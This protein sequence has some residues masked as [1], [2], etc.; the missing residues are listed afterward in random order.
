M[1]IIHLS[2]LHIGKTVHGFSMTD[3]QRHIFDEIL[4]IIDSE[5]PDAVI[6]AGDIY[7]RT[8]P[9]A[10]AVRLFDGFLYEVTRR[11]TSV[12]I[13][14]GNHDSADRVAFGGRLMSKS[15][16]YISPSYRGAE[17]PVVLHD[18]KGEVR[19]YMLPFIKP[20]HVRAAFDEDDIDTY[21][22]A[23]KR[24]VEK[25][26]IDQSVRNVLIAHQTVTG[27]ERSESE[28]IAVGGVDSVDAHIFDSF[29]YVALGHLHRPQSVLKETVRYSGSPL[30][31]SFSEADHDKSVTV[32][33]LMEKG[34]TSVSTVPLRPLRDMLI[35]RG[36]YMELTDRSFYRDIDRNAYIKAVLTDEDDVPDAMSRLRTVYP[37]I[38][39][40][41]YDNLR[42]RSR[43]FVSAAE[44]TE[45]KSE[46]DLFDDLF[47][48]QNGQRMSPEQREA[49]EEILSE[50]KER[51]R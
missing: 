30:K 3:D 17:D 39:A 2:D 21:E 9:S 15:R 14:S 1:K 29:D 45:K 26:D 6:M 37:N 19:F 48:T 4:K 33:S 43:S 47:F 22:D 31:Y 7:D 23:V 41:D 25:M 10:E 27:A 34:N 13:I 51:E 40:I 49:A 42:T 18:D 38:M 12:F 24:A 11:D 20:S 32:V 16:V 35:I 5:S 8:V 46:I 36:T 28:D 50:L 44:D